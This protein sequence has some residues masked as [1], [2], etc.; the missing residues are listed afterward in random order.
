MELHPLAKLDQRFVWHPFTQ[1][2]DWMKR[3][4]VVIVAGK[5]AVL[6]DVRGRKFLDANSSIWTNLHGHQNSKIN[7]AISRQLKK[8]A[9]SSALGLTNE[10]ASLLAEKLVQ[11][12]NRKSKTPKPEIFQGFLFRRR[13]HR[14]RS[15]TETRLRIFAADKKNQKSEI[16]FAGRRVSRRHHRRGFARSY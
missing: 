15:R 16:P 10:P 12:A 1:M 13:L 6:R 8:I 7:A 14:A 4:P 11:A 5:G 2:R 3:E 9:H